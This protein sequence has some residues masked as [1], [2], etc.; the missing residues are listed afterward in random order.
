MTIVAV[1]PAFNEEVH[2]HDVIKKAKHYVDEIIVVDDCSNDATA[3]IAQSLGV[4]VLRHESNKG[5]NEA[6]KTGFKAAEKYDPRIIVTLYAN[7]Y[8]NPEDIPK[9]V[10]PIYWLQSDVVTGHVFHRDPQHIFNMGNEDGNDPAILCDGAVK[11]DVK[12]KSLG[13]TAFSSNTF[14]VLNFKNNGCPVEVE[15]LKDVQKAGFKVKVLP[16]SKLYGTDHDIFQKYRIGVVIPAYNEELLIKTTVNGIP[17]YVNKIYVINDCSTDNTAEVLRSI[18]DPR[19]HI[20]THKVNQGVGAAILH[21]YQRSLKENMDI[22]AVMGGDNQMNPMQLPKLLMPIIEG[23]ADYTKG[24]RLLS[25]E[26][27]VGMSKWRAFGNGLL[28]MI[29][30]ISSGYWHIMDPQNGY[31]A[32]SREALSNMDLHNLYTYYGYCNDMLVKLNAFGLRTV[33]VTMP[34]RYGQER[35]TIKYSS[36]M[37]KVS[38]MLFKKFL[39]RLKMKYMVL[40]FHP[41]VL[42]YILGMILVPAGVLLGGYIIAAKLLMGWTVSANLPLMDALF[43]IMGIQFTLFAMLFDMQECNRVACQS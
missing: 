11:F 15:L 14:S 40:S 18:E 5:R 31:T 3:Y 10:E 23:K 7:G 24:N 35:S 1:I 17:E 4:N 34:A 19:L 8:H 13:F 38:I 9:L 37:G 29:T 21:G 28:T 33:D 22:V 41:L 25:E 36:Y 2:I 39:W 32:I 43:L 6:L 27:R 20:I 30:K 42:F 12:D 26:F 16:S